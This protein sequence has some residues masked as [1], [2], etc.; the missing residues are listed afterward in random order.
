MDRPLLGPLALW[1][2]GSPGVQTVTPRRIVSLADLLQQPWNQRRRPACPDGHSG[3][4][5][6]RIFSVPG[7]D[8]RTG[9]TP[10]AS[11]RLEH[12]A[13]HHIMPTDSNP[14]TLSC[15]TP[16]GVWLCSTGRSIR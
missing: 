8:I 11:G 15:T 4:R 12:Q 5:Q 3:R 6:R 10:L 14:Y 9:L 13:P 16:A 1:L 2:C 7:T